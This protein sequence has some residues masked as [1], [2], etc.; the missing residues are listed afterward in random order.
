MFYSFRLFL[1]LSIIG[2][3]V[4]LSASPYNDDILNI[5]SKVLPRVVLMSNKKDELE[6]SLSICILH[7]PMNKRAVDSFIYQTHKNYPNGIKNY[8][9]QLKKANYPNHEECVES[10]LVFLLKSDRKNMQDALGYF[11]L[12][13]TLTSSYHSSYLADGADIS[14]FIGR[15]TVPFIN[16]KSLQ[17]K[18]IELE[19]TLLRIS[20]IY[21]EEQ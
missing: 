8:S 16:I 18:N 11:T 13:K 14:M 10:T 4:M 3:L 7:D 6:E 5:F 15:K 17:N 20:K 21:Q 1:L 2:N 9:V 12:H 19:N